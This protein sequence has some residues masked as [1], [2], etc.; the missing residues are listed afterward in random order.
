VPIAGIV[1]VGLFIGIVA[2][3]YGIGGGFVLTP[4]LMYGFGIPPTI[5]IGSALSQKCGTS[6]AS[7]LKLRNYGLGE[8]RFDLYMIGASLMGVDL[9]TRILHYLDSLGTYKG[10]SGDVHHSV[11]LWIDILFLV[12]LVLTGTL[13]ARESISALK[14]TTLRGDITIPGFL[15]KLR[16]PPYVDL[17]GAG[18]K[19]V[20]LPV[21]VYLGLILGVLSSLMGIGG[22][23]VFTPIL[24]YGFGLSARHAAGTGVVLL[25]FTVALG[26]FEQARNGYVSLSLSLTILAG[27]AVG[28]VI[29][30]SIVKRT[31]NRYLRLIFSGLVLGTCGMIAWDL[32]S[33]WPA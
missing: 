30:T 2:G 15:T 12:M 4:L 1:L 18:L 10:F 22:G 28:S 32:I 7:F 19:Q 29:G 33:R 23:V 24:M 26:T 14:Q 21:I 25:F 8:P 20:S 9:G 3:M 5:A 11:Q 13:I 6:V 17:P 27:S 16:M 31:K